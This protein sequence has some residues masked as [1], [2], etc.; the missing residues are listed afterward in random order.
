M[1]IPRLLILVSSLLAALAFSAAPAS[2]VETGVNETLSQTLPVGGTAA[3]LGAD[4]V[5]IWA[6][7]EQAQ[8]A[9][10]AIDPHF[11]EWMNGKV[12]EAKARGVKVL[13]VMQRSPA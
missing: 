10:G 2:A 9:P 7:W 11:V 4:W 13:V 1:R 6:S 3:D 8:P 12:A 5:R